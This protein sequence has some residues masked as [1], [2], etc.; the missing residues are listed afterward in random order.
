MWGQCCV[1]AALYIICA[2]SWCAL[3]LKQQT[4]PTDLVPVNRSAPI[5][6]ERERLQMRIQCIYTEKT[7]TTAAYVYID[8]YTYILHMHISWTATYMVAQTTIVDVGLLLK[9]SIS[10]AWNKSKRSLRKFIYTVYIREESNAYMQ[11]ISKARHE[12]SEADYIHSS[13]YRAI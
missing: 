11:N 2:K 10:I 3:S 1:C 5:Q 13:I 9:L 8:V 12:L 4:E 6:R 7:A